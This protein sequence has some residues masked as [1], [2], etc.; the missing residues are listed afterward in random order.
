MLS[1][2]WFEIFRNSVKICRMCR[3]FQS[4]FRVLHMLG[5]AL[6]YVIDSEWNSV[7]VVSLSLSIYI[8]TYIYIY[9]ILYTYI[10]YIHILYVYCICTYIKKTFQKNK[11]VIRHYIHIWALKLHRHFNV[12]RKLRWLNFV[13][14][15]MFWKFKNFSS[16]EIQYPC[17]KL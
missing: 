4:L 6:L 8:H 17:A 9:I 13:H 16:T 1:S 11:K 3:I 5:K 2:V 10:I 12:G 15:I 14:I 7:F